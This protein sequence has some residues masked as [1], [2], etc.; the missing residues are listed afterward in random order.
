MDRLMPL[1]PLFDKTIITGD[2]I[3]Y[4][5]WGAVEYIQRYIYDRHPETLLVAGGHDVSWECQGKV[6]DT[7]SLESR[8]EILQ[9]VW[10]QDLYY[11]SEVLA[12][13][14]MLVLLN[15]GEHRYYSHQTERLRADIRKARQEERVVIIFQHEPLCTR[16]EWETAV[17]PLR[18][19]QNG[20]PA[21]RNYHNG[22]AFIGNT[23]NTDGESMDMYRLITENA[24]VVRAVFC[25]HTH[26]EGYTEISGWDMTGDVPQKR[27]I[28]QYI[29][30]AAAYDRGHMQMITIR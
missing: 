27:M 12:D 29:L 17:V 24:D 22:R 1:A 30:D 14:V 19:S 18:V 28:P 10:K 15:N 4:L 2:I 20:N 9:T 16:N 13:K 25:G 7:S 23:E 21:P 26:N 6:R 8:Q 3:D 11:H 5:T